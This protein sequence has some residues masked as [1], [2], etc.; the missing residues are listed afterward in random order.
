MTEKMLNYNHQ[1]TPQETFYWCGP[2]S[3]Q[4]VLDG[5]GI[6][7]PE[8]ELAEELGTTVG[9][10]DSINQVTRGL[11]ARTGLPYE[12]RSIPNDPPTQDQRDRMWADIV[13]T[14]GAGR[15]MVVNWVAP[16]SNYPR[17][18]PPSGLS[19]AYSGGTVYHYVAL[20]GY[21]DDGPRRVWIADSGFWPYGYWLSFEQLCTLI[22]PKGYTCAPGLPPAPTPPEARGMDVRTLSEAMGAALSPA[23]YAELLPGMVGAMRAA[24]ITTAARAAMWCAQ[25]GHESAGLRYMEEIAD[26]SAYEGRADLGNTQPGDG[27]RFKGS[28]PIQLTGRHNFTLFSRWCAEQGYTTD[29]GLLVAR[30]ELVRSDPRFGFLAA[31]WYW[32]V[33]RPQLNALADAHDLEGATRAIN[34]GLNGITD[35]RARYD[36]CSALGD[37]L[38]PEEDF[39]PALTDDQQRQLYAAICEPKPTFV[40]PEPGQEPV[41]L[42][43]EQYWRF[44][45]AATYGTGRA[46][47]RLQEDMTALRGELAA[48]RGELAALAKVVK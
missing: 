38:L 37:R 30:P 40:P 17:A 32:T 15:G 35:R 22:P 42:T 34:G 12:D 39:M 2:A 8:R 27:H 14:I 41:R 26:G 46:V 3:M 13:S 5:L 7:V 23:R 18:V 20:M 4:V 33:A 10:T 16:P 6:R 44:T 43:P 21:A 36:R 11:A 45:D 29:P 28:G 9:G 31:S 24:G 19:P 1:V 47:E 48:L 25:I